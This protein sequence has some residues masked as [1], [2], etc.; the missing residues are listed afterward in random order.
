MLVTATTVLD[1]PTN[2]RRFVADNL[3]SGVDHLLVFL[4][5]PGAPGQ[6]EVRDHLEQHPHV[7]PV[8]T[9]RTWWHGSRPDRL[10]VRQR[11]NVNVALA[12]LEDLDEV[13]W[14]VHV[15]GDEVVHIDPAAL[16]AVPAATPSL[17][18]TPLEA[19]S[20]MHPVRRPTSFKRLLDEDDLHLLT[21]LGVLDRPTNQAYFHGHVLGKSGVRPGSGLRLTLHEPV[22][23]DGERLPRTARHEHPALR[24]LHYD[25]VSGEEFVRKWRTMAAA[26]PV[27]L[28][29]D[30]ALMARAL[31]CLVGKDLPDDVASDYLARVYAATTQD[32]VRTLE[33]LRL[34]EHVDPSAGDHRPT[35]FSPAAAAR[36]EARLEEL[37]GA[38]KRPFHVNHGTDADRADA[39]HDAPH[40]APRASS[41]GPLGRL[42]RRGAG[43]R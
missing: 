22:T 12:L 18:L 9:D 13:D 26:G 37:R 29:P 10:N 16:A 7:T 6:D 5:A 30:R 24:V 3:A 15:D 19:V 17:R 14:V 23:P 34:L 8:V 43:P 31:R 4:D 38:P 42:R 2:V 27:A 1:T 36:V 35:T 39:P 28:R 41:T 21:V 33:D 32:D 40:G 20:T 25:A 11:I